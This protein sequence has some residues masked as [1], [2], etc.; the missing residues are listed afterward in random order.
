MSTPSE[1]DGGSTQPEGQDSGPGGQDS[2]PGGQ[3]SGPGGQDSGPGGQDSGPIQGNRG[4]SS[5]SAP[6]SH[7]PADVWLYMYGGVSGIAGLLLLFFAIV[8]HRSTRK[9]ILS[10]G[11]PEGHRTFNIQIPDFF[12]P[13]RKTQKKKKKGGRGKS[14]GSTDSEDAASEVGTAFSTATSAVPT[15][16]NAAA[17]AV[18]GAVYKV[19]SQDEWDEDQKAYMVRDAGGRSYVIQSE[20]PTEDDV[21]SA[22]YQS[23]ESEATDLTEV[24]EV[25]E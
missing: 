22:S 20:E 12:L 16:V 25:S 3:D 11:N 23:G 21:S 1:T 18:G 7:H 15:A 9:N 19:K 6:S 5:R 24:S 13:N 2:G 8:V 14:G 10:D 17:K 4:R